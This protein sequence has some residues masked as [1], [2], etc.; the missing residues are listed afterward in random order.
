MPADTEMTL[1]YIAYDDDPQMRSEK[2]L[3]NCGFECKCDLCITQG[4]VPDDLEAQ[5]RDLIDFALDEGT[6]VQLKREAIEKLGKMYL[7]P[8]C[9]VPRRRMWDIHMGILKKPEKENYPSLIDVS[10]SAFESKGFVIEGGRSFSSSSTLLM[11]KWGMIERGDYE[12]WCWVG[13]MYDL[14]GQHQLAKQAIEFARITFMMVVGEDVTFERE[15][16]LLWERETAQYLA[17]KE[18]PTET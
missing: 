4:E 12:A 14:I 13:V 9:E 17:G 1:C 15:R 3:E 6:S 18:K 8:S 10:L 7:H 16:V 2:L 5:I 11:R